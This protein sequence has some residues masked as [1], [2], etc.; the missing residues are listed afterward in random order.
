[1]NRLAGTEKP[2]LRK[3]TNDTTYPLGAWHGLVIGN[4]PLNSVGEWR[5]L[6]RLD[7]MEEL[8]AGNIGARPI[9]HHDSK[10]LG[11]L[12]AQAVVLLRM[13]KSSERRGRVR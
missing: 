2:R 11:W 5:K 10:V 12:E 4:P 1:M 9:R 8:L 6:A 7:K 13:W 3:A